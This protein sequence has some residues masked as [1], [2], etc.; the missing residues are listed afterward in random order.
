MIIGN[1]LR[2]DIEHRLKG[3]EVIS[4]GN[5]DLKRAAVALTVI[6][7]GMGPDVPGMPD[8]NEKS[9]GA[10]VLLT[11]RASNLKDHSGQWA[12]PGGKIDSAE[13]PIEAAMREL[14]EEVGLQLRQEDCLGVLDDFVTRSGY[15]MTPF[16]FW[17]GVD[18]DLKPDPAEVASIH[19]IPVAELL[20]EDAPKLIEN[21]TSE[22]P[23][24]QMPLG[25]T[26]SVMAPTGAI[27]YQF[28][29]VCFAGNSV[30]VSHYV[31]LSLPGAS[32][33]QCN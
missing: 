22:H 15:V 31:S 7:A 27:L 30:R 12:I 19:R 18:P 24:L 26:D 17:G 25:K 9:D 33:Q 1:Q 28:A 10:A 11:R 29:Q 2:S 21:N 3:F 5:S 23:I 20:R 32:C 6:D 16:V 14:Q 13:T 8:N 4:S